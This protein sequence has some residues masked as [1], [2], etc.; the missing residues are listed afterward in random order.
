MLTS[1]CVSKTKKSK[2][3]LIVD[4]EELFRESVVAGAA[5][6]DPSWVLRSA[7]NGEVALRMLLEEEADLLVTDL[8]MPVLDGFQLL[9]AVR[10][11]DLAPHVIVVSAHANVESQ[12]RLAHLGSLTCISKP[13][14]LPQ[15][16][17][18]FERA[19]SGPRSTVDGL[20]LAG[21][22]QLLELERHTCLLR[23]WLDERIGDL[24]F[25]RGELIDARLG[26][27][28]GRAAALEILTWREAH[29]EVLPAVDLETRNIE[30]NESL[31]F[32][33]LEAARELDESKQETQGKPALP[34]ER[35]PRA[36]PSG[37]FA[38]FDLSA[39]DLGAPDLSSR[40]LS[41][42]DWSSR[43]LSELD[44]GATERGAFPAELPP[45]PEGAIGGALVE[46]ASGAVL[47]S[48]GASEAFRSPAAAAAN[49][50]MVKAQLSLSK[51]LDLEHELEDIA[52]ILTSEVQIFR[53]L[54]E[55]WDLFL[56]AAFDRALVPL[57]SAR[58]EMPAVEQCLLAL[59]KGSGNGIAPPSVRSF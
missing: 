59:H 55:A 1:P 24:V 10:Q 27:T 4:D 3:I 16:F 41:L 51:E 22:C 46:L 58:R 40:D 38:A 45:L 32:L 36:E 9:A 47:A 53:P 18:G 42:R 57:A 12:A 5:Q 28:T 49:A 25:H 11:H 7:E 23:A 35:V 8:H 17:Q 2:S 6:A 33:L 14:P 29:L 19:L 15:L 26:T 37:S 21:F 43:T 13:V 48:C 20:T 39:L 54:G 50:E 56:V 44:R 30:K 31:S 34:R 52:M